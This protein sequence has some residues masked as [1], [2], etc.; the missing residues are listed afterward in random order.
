ML[1]MSFVQN[2][3]AWSLRFLL[4]G[5][6]F[7]DRIVLTPLFLFFLRASEPAAHAQY[8]RE[9]RPVCVLVCV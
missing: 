3:Q 7:Q 8:V 2:E 1:F 4:A 6:K 5:S 9:L